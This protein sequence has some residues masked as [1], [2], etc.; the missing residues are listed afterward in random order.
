MSTWLLGE[1][2]KLDRVILVIQIDRRVGYELSP[3]AEH[4]RAVGG[5]SAR[6]II[7]MPVL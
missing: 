4:R 3:D 7:A 2:R 5:D 6:L 1:G